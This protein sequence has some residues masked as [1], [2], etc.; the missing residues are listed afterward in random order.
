MH[1]GTC[2]IEPMEHL[3]NFIRHYKII[4][5]KKI[6][7]LDSILVAQLKNNLLAAM[8]VYVTKILANKMECK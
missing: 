1:F 7:T 4:F 5:F 3:H 8:C 2:G 6:V